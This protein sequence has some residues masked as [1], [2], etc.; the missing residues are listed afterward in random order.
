LCV[1]C[2]CIVLYIFSPFVLS[3]SYFLQGEPL[4]PGRNPVAV[5]ILIIIIK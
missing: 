3:L 4:R 5:N 2:F 1:L